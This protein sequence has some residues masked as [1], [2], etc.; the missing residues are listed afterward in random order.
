MIVIDQATHAGPHTQGL[1]R[2]WE[3]GIDHRFDHAQG[4]PTAA[5]ADEVTCALCLL[6][7]EDVTPAK[8]VFI[9][10]QRQPTC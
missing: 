9:P 10:M 1:K 6:Y 8:P 2:N 3:V 5:T 7:V 4:E